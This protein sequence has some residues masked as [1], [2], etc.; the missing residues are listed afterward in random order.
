MVNRVWSWLM[1]DGLV[2]T[3][4]NFG[5]TGEAPYHPELLDYLANRFVREGW[6]L[7]KLIRE[8]VLSRAW[9]QTTDADPAVLAADPENRL[10]GRMSRRR[11]P[12]ES[13]RDAMLSVSG[14][15]ELTVG[16]RTFPES[17]AA[18]YGFEFTEPRRSVYVPVFRNAL[19][20][21][22]EVFDFAAPSMV[23]GQRNNSTVATQALFLL[24]HPFVHERATAAAARIASA[25]SDPTVQIQHAWWLALG[26]PPTDRELR[27]TLDSGAPLADIVHA[28]FASI[29]FRYVN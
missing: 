15:L 25:S 22:F 21:I 12:A 24:N 3:V 18:D 11:L 10:Y 28:L 13:I 17:R 6:S 4:D 9:Q 16:G 26:R 29:D 19:P 8:I 14:E 23:V 7:K 2:R 20:E 5:T 27:L 1:G